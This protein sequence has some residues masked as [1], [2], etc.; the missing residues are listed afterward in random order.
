MYY[1]QLL[2]I[3]LS[4]F[5]IKNVITKCLEALVFVKSKPKQLLSSIKYKPFIFLLLNF[6]NFSNYFNSLF[7]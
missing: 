7:V 1:L 3:V 6:F 2:L 5:A 4:F